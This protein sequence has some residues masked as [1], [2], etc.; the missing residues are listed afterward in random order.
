MNED[1]IKK[2][3]EGLASKNGEAIKEAVRVALDATT[4]GLMKKSDLKAE[5]ETMGLKDSTI[6]ELVDIPGAVIKQGEEMRRIFQGK[7][8]GKT[9]DEMVAEKSEAIKNIASGG[10]PVKMTVNKTLVTR[11]T[12]NASTLGMRLPDVGQ[13]AYPNTV[14]SSLFR[15][16]NVSPGSGGVIR[17][18]DQVTATRNAAWVAEGTTKPESAITW[19]ER[20]LPIEKVADSIP[21]TKEAWADIP[22]IQGEVRRLLE[23]NLALKIDDSLYDGTGVTPEIKGVYTSAP[24]FVTT[25]YADT[26]ESANLFDLIAVVAADIAANRGSKYQPDTVLLNPMNMLGMSLSKNAYGYL[27]PPFGSMQ[28]GQIANIMGLKIIPSG[29]VTANTMVVGDFRYGTIYDL[30]DLTIEMGWIN[31]QFIKNCFTILAEQRLALLIRTGD[32]TAFRKVTNI[33]T[34]LADLETP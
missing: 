6:K 31:D 22:F 32:E 15:H 19:S 27:L 29:Q 5:L 4:A 8:T 26:V 20:L 33:T 11:A 23:I 7:Q 21:V 30:E 9:V 13:L 1:E 25:P 16:A 17:Y 24:A 14:M 12:L 18:V 28:N 34:A 3:L 2:L 10:P